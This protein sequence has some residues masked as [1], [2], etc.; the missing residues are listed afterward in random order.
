VKQE[1]G[2]VIDLVL[3][4]FKTLDFPDFLAQ[5]SLRHQTDRSKYIGSEENWEKAEKGIQEVAAEKG[6]RTVVEY[7]EAAFYGPKLDFMVR[8]ATGHGAN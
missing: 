7:G 2:K 1:V 4:I 5:V 6:L 3:Y 8:D